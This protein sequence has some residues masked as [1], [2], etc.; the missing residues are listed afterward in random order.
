MQYLICS[1]RWDYYRHILPFVPTHDTIIRG[2]IWGA[3]LEFIQAKLLWVFMLDR[4]TCM[5]EQEQ[6]FVYILE[7]G[8]NS[9]NYIQ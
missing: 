9:L 4:F 5:Y 6:K 1:I 3:C 8:K 2:A 7:N